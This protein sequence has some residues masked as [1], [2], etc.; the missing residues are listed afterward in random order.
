MKSPRSN[1]NVINTHSASVELADM[2]TLGCFFLPF[3]PAATSSATLLTHFSE[4]NTES[5]LLHGLVKQATH[6]LRVSLSAGTY[7][8]ENK[9]PS[10]S[11]SSEALFS[12][13]NF[14]ALDLAL[15]G[16]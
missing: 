15:R 6:I 8:S 1:R 3:P 11:S 16:G 5:E 9:R 7:S 13:I 14:L 12:A 4:Q 2:D 10:S